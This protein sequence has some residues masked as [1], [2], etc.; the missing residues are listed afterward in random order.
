[1]RA[2]H[3]TEYSERAR[4][5]L[6]EVSRPT[7]KPG[8]VV[9][10]VKA[11]SINPVDHKILTSDLGIN[12]DLPAI[13]HMDVAGV[14]TEVSKDMEVFSVGDEVYGC[15]GGLKGATGNID[16]AL[17]DYML[18]DASLIAHKPKSLDFA[19]AAALPLV[20]ITAWEGLFDRAQIKPQER[21]LI[22]GGTGGVGHIAV[23]LA[24]QQGAHVTSTVS[25]K[26]KGKISL[27]LGAD[28][29]VNYRDE[30]V[31]AYV[32][33]LTQGKGFDVVFDTVGG[34]TLD[35]SFQAART[36]AQVI[37]I[38]GMNTHDL[39]LMHVKGLS[40]HLI[41]MLLPMLT[42]E[43][44]SHHGYILKEIAGLVDSGKLTPLIHEERFTFE[45]INEAHALYA[46]GKHIG[47]IIVE[48]S[49]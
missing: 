38:I 10:K 33:R 23:Q 44:R 6:A 49:S 48:N 42:G 22:H 11:T 45:Q 31:E 36:N 39:T 1:M 13:L 18:A 3:V 26:E 20:S 16:G 41:F 2:Y 27:N 30:S 15:A 24:K 37:S 32:A 40:L 28:E 5:T 8:H 9:I 4:F 43:H 21:V 35:A 7:I 29:I 46:S 19:E 14:I 47:K 17:A 25:S 12:P 34:A